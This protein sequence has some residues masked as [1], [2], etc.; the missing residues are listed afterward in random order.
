ML[1]I[2]YSFFDRQHPSSEDYVE[3]KIKIIRIV[4]KSMW[5]VKINL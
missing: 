1:L 5:L 2:V 4:G 3:A